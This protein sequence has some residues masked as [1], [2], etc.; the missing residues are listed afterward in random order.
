MRA[1]LIALSLLVASACLD[2]QLASEGH[3]RI[4]LDTD[5]PLPRGGR[6]PSPLEPMPLVDT[7]RVEL[8]T[9]AGEPAC[10]TCAREFALDADGIDAGATFTVLASQ[11]RATILHAIAFRAVAVRSGL[12]GARIEVWARV[13]A[14]PRDGPRPMTLRLPMDAF[15]RALG[16]LGAPVE[17]LDGPPLRPRVI[18]RRAERR[19]CAGGAPAGTVCIP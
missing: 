15:G 8:L 19:P 13:P 9:A 10:S 5:A 11:T 16:S 1:P 2:E 4:F 7:V 17:L 14:P 6:Q 18:W 3:L 12:P